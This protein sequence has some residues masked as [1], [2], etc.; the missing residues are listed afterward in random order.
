MWPV[1]YRFIWG[2][3][4]TSGAFPGVC[5]IYNVADIQ[6]TSTRM[7]LITVSYIVKIMDT[8]ATCNQ[9]TGEHD[10]GL[11]LP[12]WSSSGQEGL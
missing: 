11:V 3:I 1:I 2:N 8:G 5:L 10:I 6:N 12:Y 9:D 7:T 4:K